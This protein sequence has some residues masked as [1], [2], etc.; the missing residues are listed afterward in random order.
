MDANS[1]HELLVRPVFDPEV[2]DASQQ[3]QRHAADL[4]RVVVS[5]DRQT[6]NT[7]VG[8]ADRLHLE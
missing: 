2:L 1:D 7:H 3:C 4:Y 8:V 5:L 6:G